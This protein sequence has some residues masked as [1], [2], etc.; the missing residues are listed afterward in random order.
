[1]FKCPS[2]EELEALCTKLPI[3]PL[4]RFS[5]FPYTLTHLHIFEPR[6]V[7]LVEQVLTEDGC[8]AIPRLAAGWEMA[9]EPKPVCS[10]A[11]IAQIVQIQKI[12]QNR[13]NILI[14]G[15]GRVSISND[16]DGGPNQLYRTVQAKLLDTPQEELQFDEQY[17]LFR[18]LLSQILLQSS[19]LSK[20]L[21]CLFDNQNIGR[22]QQINAVAH[23]FYRDAD[24]RQQ[25]LECNSLTQR[26]EQLNDLLMTVL[27][28][29]PQA[30]G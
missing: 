13:Y 21:S 1:M 8:F 3:F 19:K 4:P 25:Y 6:Y 12:P 26:V 24:Q 2:R 29:V 18:C 30:E 14:A 15:V 7:Q 16:L 5:L 10:V 27:S 17:Q 9:S 20:E 22:V 28:M 23:L 11:G